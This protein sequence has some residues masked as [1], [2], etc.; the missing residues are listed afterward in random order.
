MVKRKRSEIKKPT[1]TIYGLL[2]LCLLNVVIQP[3]VLREVNT[4]PTAII[5]VFWLLA[6]A[7]GAVCLL[8]AVLLYHIRRRQSGS[9][10]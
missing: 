8:C 3:L 2:G 7:F 1:L 4:S 10:D 5:Y 6:Y 9:E